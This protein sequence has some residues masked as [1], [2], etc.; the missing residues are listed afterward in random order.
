MDTN[1][2]VLLAKKLDALPNGF[3]QTSDGAEI[4]LLAK[5]FT[6]EEAALTASLQPDLET[7]GSISARTGVSPEELRSNLKG[8]SRRGLINAGKT[9]DGLGYGL[10]PFVVGIYEMQVGTI[11]QELAQLFE[12]YYRQAFGEML[13]VKP[14][15]HR[16]IP[17]NETVHNNMEIHPFESASDLVN[18]AH[19]WGVMDCICRKQKA[20]IGEP[21][22][23]PVDVCMIME[24]RPNAF[25]HSPV[26]RVI[27]RIEALSTLRRAAEAGLVH[28]VSNNQHGVH[29]ICNCCTCSCG[30]LR[31]MSNLGIA[32]VVARSA[33]INQV[34]QALCSGCE[35]C[36]K[37]CQFGALSV[38]DVALVDGV[39]CVGCGVC[40]LG[41]S[42]GALSL[43]R[44][45]EEET[46]AIPETLVEWGAQRA[47]SRGLIQKLF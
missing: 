3:P 32:N 46:Q 10:M 25:D 44:R 13:K 20:L 40:V 43:V 1:P 27:D 29:Y 28:S 17:V 9:N 37:L 24:E 45:P 21:C 36:V 26:I 22:G 8:L 18:T 42:T 31:G 7:I 38:D 23:H 19:S 41:C 34:D 14:Q 11:D 16:V 5:L 33:F 39:R 15:F 47:A 35:E 4:K 2:Y 6:P 30:I 12:N